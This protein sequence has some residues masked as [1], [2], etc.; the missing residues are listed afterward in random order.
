[1]VGNISCLVILHLVRRFKRTRCTEVATNPQSAGTYNMGLDRHRLCSG[2]SVRCSLGWCWHGHWRELWSKLVCD[3]L[4]CRH[5]GHSELT[6]NKSGALER[7]VWHAYTHTKRMFFFPAVCQC[8]LVF[9]KCK[10]CRCC[11]LICYLQC[12]VKLASNTYR[13]I[14]PF[15]LLQIFSPEKHRTL[16][17]AVLRQKHL[18]LIESP[19]YFVGPWSTQ[20]KKDFNCFFFA[21]TVL[22]LC[23][24]RADFDS[25][26][27]MF[28][29]VAVTG[30][31]KSLKAMSLPTVLNL[32]QLRSAFWARLG[33]PQHPRFS[34][35][36]SLERV[37]LPSAATW[38]LS[39]A[40]T[41][42]A[43]WMELPLRCRNKKTAVTA[44]GFFIISVFRICTRNKFVD[45][46]IAR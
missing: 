6:N 21:A 25:Y 4:G 16:L 45:G 39:P 36:K 31:M 34:A 22:E 19:R 5:S 3:L 27:T 41:T 29:F 15:H 13:G 8:V 37:S 35:L 17:L 43:E 30:W 40:N 11:Y 32:L 24:Y 26:T 14:S 12:L 1:M 18:V 10:T 7:G 46:F 20:I 38:I 33:L 44:E 9:T 23:Q 28:M 42:V 2:S